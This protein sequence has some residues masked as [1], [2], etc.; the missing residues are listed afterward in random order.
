M[1]QVRQLLSIALLTLP[2]CAQE[3]E[4]ATLGCQVRGSIPLG[5][6]QEVIG[7]K[8][9]PGVGASLLAEIDLTEGYRMRV[10]MGGDVWPRGDWS[11]KP[12]VEGRAGTLHLSLEGVMMLNDNTPS[13]GP[14]LVAGLGAYAWAISSKDTINDTNTTARILHVAGTA[15]FGYR[16][17]R[18]LD[19]ELRGLAGRIDPTLFAAAIQGSATYRF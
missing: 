11:G 9:L 12:G 19:L 7:G 5:G 14:Y 3:A 15:G 17:T 4:P 6:L 13:S 8:P 10:E 1:I 2:L 16:F 18:H